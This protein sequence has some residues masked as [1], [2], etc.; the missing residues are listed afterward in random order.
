[1]IFD[2]KWIDLGREPQCPPDPAYPDGL[3]LDP[4]E[5]PACKVELAHPTKRCGL[6]LVKCGTCGTSTAVTTAG[7]A[8]DPRSLMM[9]CMKNP[10]RRSAGA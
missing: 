6:Y 8:D 9:P 7:R 5:R 4:G 10:P 3:D 1:M 2:I